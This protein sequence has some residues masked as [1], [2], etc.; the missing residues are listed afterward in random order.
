MKIQVGDSYSVR[1]GKS[2]F[3]YMPITPFERCYELTERKGNKSDTLYLVRMKC[4]TPFLPVCLP[5]KLRNAIGTAL[6]KLNSN[7]ANCRSSRT[8]VE[9]YETDKLRSFTYFSGR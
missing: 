7:G 3:T 4:V 2:L 6:S 5:T 1:Y 8:Y 9:E